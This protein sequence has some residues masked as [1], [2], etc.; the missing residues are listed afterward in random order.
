MPVV[1]DKI[2]D[3]GALVS[4]RI[5][6]PRARQKALER[7]DLPVPPSLVCLAVVDTG[8]Y[9]SGVDVGILEALEL[10]GEVDLVAVRTASTTDE[11]HICPVYAVGLTLVHLNDSLRFPSLHVLATHFQPEERARVILGR[12]VLTCCH[13]EYDGPSRSFT[14]AF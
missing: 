5:G 1:S 9:L 8:A 7:N 3:E 14:F 6:V 11:P 10:P 2:G 12:D 13:F 4:V